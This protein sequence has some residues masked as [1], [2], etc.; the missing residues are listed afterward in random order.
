[1]ERAAL[2]ARTFAVLLSALAMLVALRVADPLPVERLRLQQFD[3]LQRLK[4]RVADATTSPVIIVA[5]DETSL[6]R[7][8]QWPWPRSLMAR[9]VAALAQQAPASVGFDII[10]AE[11][12]RLSPDALADSLVDLD[13]ALRAHLKALP[14]NDARLAE[15]LRA[16]PAVLGDA[17]LVLDGN[18]PAP[19]D[20]ARTPSQTA[21]ADPKPHLFRFNG[22]LRNIDL[23]SAAA[24]GHALLSNP[25]EIDGVTRRIATASRVGNAIVPDLNIEMLRLLVG[26]NWFTIEADGNGIRAIR[27]AD[28]TIPT[29]TDGR[30]WLYFS[31]S[32]SWRY[33]SA[34]A[35][36]DGELAP[37]ALAGRLLLVGLTGLGEKDFK[38]T[39]IAP[40]MSG[41]EIRAQALENMISRTYLVRPRVP[42]P[43]EAAITLLAGLLIIMVQP[44]LSPRYSV[45]PL[46][47]VLAV[48][49][50][51]GWLAFRDYRLLIDTTYPALS[52][53]ALFALTLSVTLVESERTRRRLEARLAREREAAQ[54]IEGE[55][56]AARE[57]QMGILPRQ[58]PPFP[59]RDEFTLHATIEPARAVGGDMYDFFMLDD[60]RL[61]FM[62]GDVSGKGVPASLF[63]A[64]SKSLSKSSAL[65]G[66]VSL[67]E[68]IT[69]ANAEIA[70][71]NVA[72]MFVTLFAGILNVRS[73]ELEYCNA[74]HEPPL[75]LRPGQTPTELRGDGGPPLCVIDDFSY[76]VERQLLAPGAALL[77]FTDGATDAENR[78]GERFGRARIIERL[79]SLPPAAPAQEIV[80]T[81]ALA[82]HDF[83]RGVDQADDITLLALRRAP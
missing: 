66:G 38:T 81:L 49:A 77:L 31:P 82:I 30:V 29:D 80:E 37:D 26:A 50:A 18:P 24:R 48:L 46:A 63:M 7:Y 25:P 13:P 67:G 65:R 44:L 70:R 15:S 57:I 68:I 33:V 69:R 11:P 51:A 54:R 58:F 43:L 10:F 27:L 1:M 21:G 76:P 60:E 47:L 17:G 14:T 62:I 34:A 55:L 74:G 28:N 39:P 45:A 23:L 40:L 2:S 42:L 83:D 16:I 12:D 19:D 75:R 6:K 71:E 79:A 22:L 8:G 64:L 32:Q 4:P 73:G 9:L 3:L 35:V 41:V 5:I 53:I 72:M 78:V 61:Y 20:F 36:L 59:D 56:S 52:T